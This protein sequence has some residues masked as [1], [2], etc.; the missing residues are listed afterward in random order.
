MHEQRVGDGTAD[1]HRPATGR[2]SPTPA[3]KTPTRAHVE[4]QAGP[5][6]ALLVG[7]PEEVA[8]KILRHSEAL[9]GISRVTFQMD[10]AV[11]PHEK[12]LQATELIGSRVA[13]LLRQRASGAAQQTA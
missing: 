7:S 6:G 12:I 4:A 13:P 9:G 8:A 10:V 3:T 1:R 11:L 5:L 2:E